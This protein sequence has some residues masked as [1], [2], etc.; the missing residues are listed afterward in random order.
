MSADTTDIIM[1][2]LLGINALGLLAVLLF[3]DYP[4]P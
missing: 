2:I 1:G 4:W 3:G